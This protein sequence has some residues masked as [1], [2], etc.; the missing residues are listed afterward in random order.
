MT[1]FGKK[2]F[3]SLYAVERAHRVPIQPLPPGHPTRLLLAWLLNYRGREIVLRLA[4]EL[5]NIQFNDTRISFNPDFS[6][7]VQ[8]C[9]SQFSDVKKLLQK[10][11][12]S[13]KMFY[14]AK[15]CFTSRGCRH[16][17]LK[18]QKKL[19]LGLMRMRMPSIRPGGLWLRKTDFIISQA[20]IS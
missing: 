13:Y 5:Q 4:R 14:P 16:I 17:S 9:R 19:Q 11:Q 15:L 2:A 12:A 3:T 1:V 8:K 18:M 10:L 20:W 6:A 7:E